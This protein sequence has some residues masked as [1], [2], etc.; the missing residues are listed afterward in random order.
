[1]DKKTKQIP[2]RRARTRTFQETEILGLQRTLLAIPD[3]RLAWLEEALELAYQARALP[4]KIDLLR[5]GLKL[6]NYS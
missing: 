5:T 4:S 1:M 3:Q 6:S 2:S